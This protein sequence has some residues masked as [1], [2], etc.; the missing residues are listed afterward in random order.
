ME[1]FNH[2]K[3]GFS[4]FFRGV[5]GRLNKELVFEAKKIEKI[6]IGA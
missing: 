6:E 4:L 1:K 2:E 3:G 5:V